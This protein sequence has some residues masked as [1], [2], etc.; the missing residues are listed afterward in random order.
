MGIDLEEI[1]AESVN[2]RASHRSRLSD[3]SLLK[4]H[5][6]RRTAKAWSRTDS[7]VRRVCSTGFWKQVL[8]RSK[9]FFCE[10]WADLKSIGHWPQIFKLLWPLLFIAGATTILPVISSH[11]LYQVSKAC[12]PDSGF[13]V[14]FGEYDIW[15]VSGFFQITLGFGE[16]SFSTA[17]IIDVCWDVSKSV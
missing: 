14:G 13:Y 8:P 3:I 11:K 1:D 17:K 4:Y 15:D 7:R 5:A 2:T 9:L 16:L 10:S 6:Q 12:Q